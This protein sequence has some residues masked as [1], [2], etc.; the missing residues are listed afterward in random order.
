[1]FAIYQSIIN[2]NWWGAIKYQI[3]NW[4]FCVIA[5]KASW[6]VG[7]LWAVS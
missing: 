2:N 6:K 4:L 5:I 1:M 3:Q 7:N